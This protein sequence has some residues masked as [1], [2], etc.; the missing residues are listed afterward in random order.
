M[1]LDC[2]IRVSM[3]CFGV[4]NLSLLCSLIIGFQLVET[5]PNSVKS[6][7]LRDLKLHA[8][9][10]SFNHPKSACATVTSV[11]LML[12]SV[13]SKL[14]RNYVFCF[15]CLGET[16]HYSWIPLCVW[17]TDD[18][19]KRQANDSKTQQETTLLCLQRTAFW[20]YTAKRHSCHYPRYPSPRNPSPILSTM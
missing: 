3:R 11:A 16:Q 14:S 5:R 9:F 18:D 15:I 7:T 6:I 1:R 17:K 13:P 2:R 4:P 12:W 20:G 8:R 10:C 19:P